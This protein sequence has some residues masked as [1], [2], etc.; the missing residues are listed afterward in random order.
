MISVG[1]DK[2]GFYIPQYYLDLSD[3]AARDGIDPAK[4]H[5]GI[6]QE[7]FAVAPHDEDIVTL[8]ANAAWPLLEEVDREAIDTVILATETGIDHSKAAAVYVHRLLALRPNCRAVELKQA[9]YSGT[10]GL[11]MA[12]AYVATHPGKKVLL[13]TADISRYEQHSPAEATQG[14]A[15]VA[16][17]ISANPRIASLDPYSG[18]Y[19]ED[20]MDF[21]R[22]NYRHTPLVDGKFSTQ[23]Y[24]KAAEQAYLD[25]QRNGGLDFADFQQYCYHLPFSKMGIKA[26]QRLC[27]LNHS[28]VDLSR[29]QPG[30][31]YNR[32]IGNSYTAALYLS[33][34]SALDHRDDLAGARV[35][36]MSYGSGCVAEFFS[37]TVSEHYREMRQTALHHAM[38]EDR[39]PLSQEEYNHF[40]QRGDLENS[41]AIAFAHHNR[42][43]FRFS[44]I[45]DDKRHYDMQ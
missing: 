5:Q 8:S 45:E 14:S 27:R 31:I 6:G 29:L 18:S 25:Y 2:I 3:L 43:R 32:Q 20:V 40:W 38:L 30:M 23:I 42:S 41:G 4:Y 36:M 21:W 12:C 24:I 9:C 28:E 17:L 39:Q 26:H 22:P 11:Q 15:A 13:L 44:G 35:A 37:L 33:L 1:I 7:R 34:C 16:M 10:A 19:T